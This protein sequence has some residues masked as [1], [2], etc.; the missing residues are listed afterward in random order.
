MTS[1]CSTVVSALT[2]FK[3]FSSVEVAFALSF[4]VVE[5]YIKPLPVLIL[6]EASL[7]VAKN[8]VISEISPV[9]SPFIISAAIHLDTPSDIAIP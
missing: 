2:L 6:L 3:I 4:F 9:E 1:S 8:F 7:A 5:R